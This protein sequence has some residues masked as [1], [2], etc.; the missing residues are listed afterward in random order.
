[1]WAARLAKVW[2]LF[3]ER[4]R[5]IDLMILLLHEN[6][7]DLFRHGELTYGLALAYSFPIIANGFILIV[8]IVA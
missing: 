4:G 6:V 5:E 3:T 8:E 7:T 1:M 2:D